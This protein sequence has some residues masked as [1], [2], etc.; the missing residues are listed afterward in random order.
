MLYEENVSAAANKQRVATVV[1]H[2]LAHQVHS[3]IL[4][5]NLHTC[6]FHL[7]SSGSEI[8]SR[9]AGGPTYG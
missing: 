4:Q 3:L 1:A 2:E 6:N 9:P 8:S 5:A 7:F